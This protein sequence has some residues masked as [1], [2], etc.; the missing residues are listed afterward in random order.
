[1]TVKTGV[2]RNV[3]LTAK[4]KTN[5]AS[6]NQGFE[7]PLVF[8][9]LPSIKRI[10]HHENEHRN[11]AKLLERFAG[12]CRDRTDDLIV[13]KD[14]TFHHPLLIPQRLQAKHPHTTAKRNWNVNRRAGVRQRHP[15][16]EASC[17][18]LFLSPSVCEPSALRSSDFGVML[19]VN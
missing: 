13:A 4:H 9:L 2:A 7:L 18:F 11:R 14:A 3:L 10:L 16:I 17:F 19:Y 15:L 5:L 1:M 8:C 6:V 12:A